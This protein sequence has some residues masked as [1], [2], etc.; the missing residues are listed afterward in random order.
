MANQAQDMYVITSNTLLGKQRFTES[1][2][3]FLSRIQ[4]ETHRENGFLGNLD[5]S[6]RVQFEFN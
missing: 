6:I 2:Y 1:Y 4:L 3:L 5:F